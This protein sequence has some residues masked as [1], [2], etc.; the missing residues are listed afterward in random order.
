MGELITLG[1]GH[2]SPFLPELILGQKA[3]HVLD[4]T[5]YDSMG[6]GEAC[7]DIGEN[8]VSAGTSGEEAGVATHYGCS[9][10][11]TTLS[12]SSTRC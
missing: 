7:R 10:A 1:N 4:D 2:D 11:S 3:R 12:S 5:G 9:S 6:N 8:L